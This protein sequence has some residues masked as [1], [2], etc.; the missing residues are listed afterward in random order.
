MGGGVVLGILG[1]K[2]LL[3]LFKK[4][5]DEESRKSF[6]YDKFLR[7]K[8]KE[9]KLAFPESSEDELHFEFMCRRV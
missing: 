2:A 9:I 8:L 6:H 3:L 4:K 1:I 5:D 7:N